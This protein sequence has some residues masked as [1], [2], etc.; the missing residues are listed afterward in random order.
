MRTT[1]DYLDGL[2]QLHRLHGEEERTATWRQSM[3]TL[4]KGVESQ[5]RTVPLEGFHPDALQAS[6]RAALNAHLLDELDWLSA[7]SAAAALYELAAALPP[8]R[9]SAARRAFR[10]ADGG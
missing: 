9:H 8:G 2:V 5:R 7:P 1:R 10:A 3:A 4:A 6:V